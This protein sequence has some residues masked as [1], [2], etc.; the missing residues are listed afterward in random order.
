MN[1]MSAKVRQKAA[2]VVAG[3]IVVTFA[4]GVATPAVA[5]SIFMV[6]EHQFAHADDIVFTQP[7]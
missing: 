6:R 4:L 2:V 7:P 3:S 1:S 5:L